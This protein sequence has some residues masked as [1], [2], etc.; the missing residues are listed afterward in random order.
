MKRLVEFAQVVTSPLAPDD[1]RG[2][3][4]VIDGVLVKP[5]SVL[6]TN[7]KMGIV[8]SYGKR[9]AGYDSVVQGEVG[10]SSLICHLL[11]EGKLYVALIEQS[12]DCMARMSHE[13][14]RGY[15]VPANVGERETATK[16]LGEECVQLPNIEERAQPLNEVE[17]GLTNHNTAWFLMPPERDGVR[18]GFSH[19]AVRIY[20][21][22]VMKQPDGTFMFREEYTIPTADSRLAEQIGKS[23]FYPLNAVNMLSQCGITKYGLFL[24]LMEEYPEYI[25][26]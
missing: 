11:H 8:A 1:Q 20:P 14:S 12:R 17:T 18:F 9:Q 2:W 3:E 7:R 4:C 23:V 19:W 15:R 24:L 6:L 21:E 13:I 5:S 25:R 22:K 10:G 26:L 16:E